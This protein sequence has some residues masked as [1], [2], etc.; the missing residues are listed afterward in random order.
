MTKERTL[1]HLA[2]ARAN[3][4][5]AVEILNDEDSTQAA[6]NWAGVAAFYAAVHYVNAYLWETARLEPV[7]HLDRQNI[8]SNWPVLAPL[9]Q[10]FRTLFTYSIDIRYSPQ[11]QIRRADLR[12]MIE[13]DLVRIAQAVEHELNGRK[14]DRT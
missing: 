6:L 12:R 11:F 9:S 1:S 7:N 3:R 13:R 4:T 10:A 8:I 5:Y 14:S 2:K